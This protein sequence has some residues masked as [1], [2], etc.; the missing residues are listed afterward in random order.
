MKIHCYANLHPPLAFV[1]IIIWSLRMEMNHEATA[2]LRQTRINN[3]I[4][5]SSV[6]TYNSLHL[7]CRNHEAWSIDYREGAPKDGVCI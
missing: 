7:C 1:Y 5:L 3:L 4:R 2:R 6:L